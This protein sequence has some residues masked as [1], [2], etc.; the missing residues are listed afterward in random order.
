MLASADMLRRD[1]HEV[2]DVLCKQRAP[3]HDRRR[4]DLRVRAPREPELDDGPPV[5]T[6]RPKHLGEAS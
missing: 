5:D 6:G 3:V 2:G 4:K 1:A